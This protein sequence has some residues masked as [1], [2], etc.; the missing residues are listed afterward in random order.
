[1]HHVNWWGVALVVSTLARNSLTYMPEPKSA[2]GFVSNP[3]YPV[4]YHFLQG[5]LA[6]NPASSG[7]MLTGPKQ[8]TS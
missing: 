7:K 2:P 6:L 8:S 3:F 5:V 4:F 1:M